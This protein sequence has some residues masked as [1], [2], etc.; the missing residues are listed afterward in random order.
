M[1]NKTIRKYL[2]GGFILRPARARVL[3]WIWD[4]GDRWVHFNEVFKELG[5]CKK[6]LRKILRLMTELRLVVIED[7][8]RKR[9][10]KKIRLRYHPRLIEYAE[11]NYELSREG[12]INAANDPD[13]YIEA[14]VE[15]CRKGKSIDLRRLFGDRTISS[16]VNRFLWKHF[17]AYRKLPL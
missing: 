2:G 3:W 15:M 10:A 9:R 8:G 16:W 13:Y 1:D 11:Q 7:N 12:V 5:M 6:H 17:P 14:I 4:N